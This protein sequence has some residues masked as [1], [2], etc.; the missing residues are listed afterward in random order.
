MRKRILIFALLALVS[1]VKESG[2]F[3]DIAGKKVTFTARTVA[4]KTSLGEKDGSSWPVLWQAGDRIAVNGAVSDPLGAGGS[5]SAQFDVPGVSAPYH[6]VSPASALTGN[7][8]LTIPSEQTYAAGSFDPAAYVMTASS[9]DEELSFSPE[10][11]LFSITPTG[12]S[13]RLITS[14]RLSSEGGAALSGAFTTDWSALTAGEDSEDYVRMVAPDGVARVGVPV[15][16]SGEEE[17]ADA[18]RVHPVRGAL[19]LPERLERLDAA[20]EAGAESPQPRGSA[21]ENRN[22]GAARSRLPISF[23][24]AMRT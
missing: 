21:R 19:A 7:E 23:W 13:E 1:C 18:V 22:M 3:D 20:G 14:V 11:A 2:T 24:A 5:P 15:L 8:T 10:V 4:T 6:A 16:P 17:V 9:A 12:D